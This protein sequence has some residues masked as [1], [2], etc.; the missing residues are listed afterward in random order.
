PGHFADMGEDGALEIGVLRDMPGPG[1]HFYCPIWWE[2]KIVPDTIIEPGQVGVVTSKMGDDL[3]TGEF[4]VS[5]DLYQTKHKG[6]LRK[7]LAPGRYRINP[8]AY[9]VNV[10]TTQEQRKDETQIKYSG[11]VQ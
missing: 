10:I 1:R 9:E 3:P 2:R 8:Y 7:V 4:L 11:W 6:I 5:G